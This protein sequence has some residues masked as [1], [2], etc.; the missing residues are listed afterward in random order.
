MSKIGTLVV[1]GFSQLVVKVN[2]KNN[3]WRFFSKLLRLEL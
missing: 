1:Y 3:I 2:N